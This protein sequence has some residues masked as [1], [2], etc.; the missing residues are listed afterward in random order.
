MKIVISVNTTWNIMNFRSGLIRSLIAD[1]HEVIA[2]SPAD[3]F[4]NEVVKLN[5]RHIDIEMENHGTSPISDFKLF[6]RYMKILRRERPDA[7]LGFTI[8]PNIYGSLACNLLDIPVINNISGLGTAFIRQNMLTKIVGALYR[9]GLKRSK[10]VFFQNNNDRELFEEYKL[11]KHEITGLLP[12]SGIDLQKF[13][14][15][16][17]G[18]ANPCPVFLLVARVLWDKGVQEYVD[19]ARTVKTECPGARFQ[20]L[21]FLDP[22]NPNGVPEQTVQGWI[23]EGTIE[24][25][26]SS[27]DVRQ[28]I[29]IA[30][31]IVL[32]SY[33]EGTPRTLLEAAAMGKPVIATDVPG[34]REVVDH[35][36]NGYLCKV[37]DAQSL[38]RSCNEFLSLDAKSKKLMGEAS[39]Q[40]VEERFDE[41][42]VIEAYK[43]QIAKLI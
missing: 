7:Y 20:L 42:L 26:G 35:A 11:V 34:C 22:L 18:N 27:N 12:G 15:V 3:G 36:S 2:V 19:A 6:L 25:L 5:C 17:T 30:D 43:K 8:K 41:K 40:L 10:H 14:P 1:G 29:K 24:Y 4:E 33:R 13:V 21:G 28:Q 31:C 38:A 23:D 16:A 9:N 32:P 39:R 37:C